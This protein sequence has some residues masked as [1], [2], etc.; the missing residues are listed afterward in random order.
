MDA[1]QTAELRLRL[2]RSGLRKWS[3]RQRTTPYD[4][5]IHNELDEPEILLIQ[6][7][8]ASM[9]AV[10]AGNK[11]PGARLSNRRTTPAA[12]LDEALNR[13]NRITA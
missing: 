4:M 6:L 1:Y 7:S 9:I 11:L 3:I 8:D 13:S 5:G 12:A 10:H 2:N